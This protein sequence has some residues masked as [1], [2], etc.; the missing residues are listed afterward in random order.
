MLNLAD[1]P[2]DAFRR[3]LAEFAY[4]QAERLY[5]DDVVAKVSRRGT[6]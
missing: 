3:Y 1:E 6:R 4:V 5:S 2:A